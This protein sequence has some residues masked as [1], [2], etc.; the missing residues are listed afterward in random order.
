MSMYILK[1]EQTGDYLFSTDR[2]RMDIQVIFRFISEQSYWAQGISIETVKRSIENSLCFGIYH[3]GEQVGFARIITDYATIAYLG[4]VFVDEAH[5]GKG[6]SKALMTFMQSIEEMKT[7]RRMILLTRDAHTLYAQYGFKPLAA[8][9][10][11][12]ELH[13]PDIYKKHN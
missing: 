8:P 3:Q 5:R 6:L 4:D 9:Q 2:S 12:M 13:R 11:Y 1:E 10:N 7:L